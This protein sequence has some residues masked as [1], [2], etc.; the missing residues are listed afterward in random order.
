M[1]KTN[2][3]ESWNLNPKEFTIEEKDGLLELTKKIN[4]K[5]KNALV[6]YKK[7]LKKYFSRD[8]VFVLTKVK[9]HRGILS[10][11]FGPSQKKIMNEMN[12]FTPSFLVKKENIELIVE[13]FTDHL[14]VYE[15]S[16]RESERFVFKDYKYHVANE[17]YFK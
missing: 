1:N 15:L 17:I 14:K 6:D 3:V 10:V 2:K 7:I 8:K 11:I 5:S 9:K 16:N 4:I 13:I 12:T